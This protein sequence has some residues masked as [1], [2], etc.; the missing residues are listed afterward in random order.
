[1]QRTSY[2]DKC[3]TN[4][5]PNI[6]TTHVWTE[7]VSPTRTKYS[8]CHS[9]CSRKD[10][11]IGTASSLRN[12]FSPL[13]AIFWGEPSPKSKVIRL[14]FSSHC[15][16]WKNFIQIR[17]IYNESASYIGFVLLPT[18]IA[19]YLGTQSGGL[20][21]FITFATDTTWHLIN[22]RTKSSEGQRSVN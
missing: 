12:R 4:L 15:C 19:D 10:S 22:G 13:F 8:V 21:I 9:M 14:F 5:R 20:G 2:F 18:Q 16:T 17:G 6:I 11:H 1:M 7:S 3:T